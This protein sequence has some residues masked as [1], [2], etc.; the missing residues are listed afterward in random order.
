MFNAVTCFLAAFNIALLVFVTIP[1]LREDDM[2]ICEL[3][4]SHDICFAAL[5]R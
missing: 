3:S 5:N 4:H 1:N 2:A